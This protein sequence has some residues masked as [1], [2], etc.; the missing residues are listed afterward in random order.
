MAKKAIAEL[1]APQPNASKLRAFV[2]GIGS[3]ISFVPHLKET[4]ETLK[5]AVTFIRINLP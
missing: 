1:R 5:W 3:T 2:A 4:Y